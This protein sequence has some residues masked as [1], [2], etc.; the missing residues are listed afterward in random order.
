[1]DYEFPR[2]HAEHHGGTAQSRNEKLREK[3]EKEGSKRE[4]SKL[5]KSKVKTPYCAAHGSQISLI[6]Y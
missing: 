5:K 3:V 2:R 4:R 1:M 6:H